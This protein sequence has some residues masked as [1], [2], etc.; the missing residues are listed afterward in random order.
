MNLLRKPLFWF[1]VQA[2]GLAA[3]LMILGWFDPVRVGDTSD[4]EQ[5]PF[6]TLAEALAHPRTF[7]YPLFLQLA[8]ALAPSHQAVAPLDFACHVLAVFLFWLGLKRVIP[9]DWTSMAVA[10][11]LFYSNIFLRY[12]NNLAA[13]SLASSLAIATI[14]WLMLTLFAERPRYYH[15]CGL[16]LLVF[17]AYQVRPAYLFLIPLI[18]LL[19]LALDWLVAPSGSTPRRWRSLAVN[20][21]LVVLLPYLAF[22]T[23]RWSTVGHFSLVSFGGNNFAAIT[24]M[25]LTEDDVAGLPPDLRPVA[26]A[27][28][29]NRRE[30]AQRNPDYTAQATRSYMAIETPFDLNIVEVC[31]PAARETC[32][33]DWPQVNRTLWRLASAIVAEK[34]DY[35]AT[36]LVK[37]FIRG[38]YMIVSEIIMNPVYF[39]LL[40]ALG[41]VH[42]GSVILHKR[43]GRTTVDADPTLF[44]EI[45]AL[46]LIAVSFALAS[47]LLV[48]VTSPALGRFMDAAAVFLPCILVRALANRIHMVRNFAG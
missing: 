36:W 15:W 12:G 2:I 4:Y 8:D 42:V 25:Y 14:G 24:C 21:V 45:N 33:H 9:S 35:Y 3:A 32:G 38:V 1:V 17:A 23:A 10:S 34:P 13:D 7:G 47:V 20:L 30:L 46:A 37:A 28:V 48:I 44:I 19:G 39:L 22:C 11:S 41:C 43:S 18:P 16:A 6:T 29:K 40:V 26:E 31:I 27:V 5:F